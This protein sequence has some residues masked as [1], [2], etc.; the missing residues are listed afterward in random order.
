MS[1]SVLTTAQAIDDVEFA[2]GLFCAAPKSQAALLPSLVI[3]PNG[4]HLYVPVS[5]NVLA[6]QQWREAKPEGAIM[7]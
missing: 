6:G 3:N 1:T 4:T 7:N 5:A 2:G